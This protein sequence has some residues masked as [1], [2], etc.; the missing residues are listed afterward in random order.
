MGYF[1]SI[2]TNMRL[3]I[4]DSGKVDFVDL[5]NNNED[6]HIGSAINTKQKKMEEENANIIARQIKPQIKNMVVQI[7]PKNWTNKNLSMMMDEIISQEK[8]QLIS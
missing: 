1:V 4:W 6:V 3:D 8:K 5:L 2:A 7:L